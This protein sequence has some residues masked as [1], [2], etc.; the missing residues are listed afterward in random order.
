MSLK[1][2]LPVNLPP[3]SDAIE[4]A[5]RLLEMVKS[6]ELQSFFSAA[7]RP[8]GNWVAIHSKQFDA[9]HKVGMLET[10]KHDLLNG[11]GAE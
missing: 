6:G 2:V 3:N 7:F 11:M 10:M 5:E 9:L 8:D 4:K 1:V